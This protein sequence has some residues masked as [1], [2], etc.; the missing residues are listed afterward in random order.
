MARKAKKSKNDLENR[1]E[2]IRQR[3][4]ALIIEPRKEIADDL[5]AE[6]DDPFEDAFEEGSV[7]FAEL[8]EIDSF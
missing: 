8:A 4:R 6:F 7:D 5:N 2:L 1:L 3:H